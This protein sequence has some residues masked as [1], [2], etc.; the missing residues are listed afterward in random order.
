MANGKPTSPKATLFFGAVFT[1][2]GLFIML[3]G[4]GLVPVPGGRSQ[5][6]APLWVAASAGLIFFFAGTAILLQGLGR[7]NG[8]GEL[9]PG[10]PGW[11]RALQHLFVLVIFLCFAMIGSWIALYG[12]A[13]QFSGSFSFLGI[14]VLLARI[15]F[16][17]GALVCWIGTILLAVSSARLLIA[18]RS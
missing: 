11:M 16:G 9:P 13:G 8:K 7:A 4:S 14:G 15:A 6:H 18:P 2:F 12:E 17:F 5:L 3:I 10:A 1:G